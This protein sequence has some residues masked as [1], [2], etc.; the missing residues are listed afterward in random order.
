[1][2][3][4]FSDYGA[5]QNCIHCPK[6]R[7]VLRLTYCPDLCG[8]AVFLTQNK[9]GLVGAKYMVHYVARRS[10]FLLFWQFPAQAERLKPLNPPQRHAGSP[11]LSDDSSVLNA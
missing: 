10:G 6:T 4:G 7:N 8:K 3:T 5:G 2:Q 11:N 9:V 1:A